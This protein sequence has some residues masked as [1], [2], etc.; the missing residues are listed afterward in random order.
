MRS[1]LWQ[2]LFLAFALLSALSLAGFAAWQ[3]FEFRRG[4]IG[5][6]EEVTALRV[7]PLAAKLGSAYAENGSWEFLR[8][9]RE[10]FA[11][12]VDSVS[13]APNRSRPPPRPREDRP[14]RDNLDSRDRSPDRAGPPPGGPR[15]GP[16]AG[17]PGLLPRLL[18]LDANAK[19]V[20]G[21]LRMDRSGSRWPIQANGNVVGQLLLEPLPA[22]AS[23]AEISFAQSQT[24]NAIVAVAV[25]LSVALLLAFALARWLL[26][27]VR[28][29][30]QGTRALSAGDFSQRVAA[31]RNDELGALGRDFNQLASTLEQHREARRQWGAD[32]SHELRTPLS[33]L[34]GEIQAMQDGVR[35]LAQGGLASLQA[36]CER[37]GNL[38]EDLYQLSL[39]DAGALEY[40]YQQTDLGE[41]VNDV[42]DQHRTALTEAGLVI[43]SEIATHLIAAV[44]ARRIGQLIDNLLVNS[45]RYTDAP[46]VVRVSLESQGERCLLIVEDSAPGVPESALRRLFDRLFRVD[47]SRHRGSG[48]AGLGLAIAQAIVH[49]HGGE[50]RATH[51]VFGG[52]RIEV[53]FAREPE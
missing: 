13:P 16:P 39:A 18:V 36:E 22:P 52:L 37:L 15:D 31:A 19:P 29:L 41:L 34:R 25:A 23:Q 2:K 30:T 17:P 27:P 28:A 44:D 12:L 51:S 6:L 42:L 24:R 5:Y 10:G 4:F 46:G 50:I 26:A 21:N 40:R 8:D 45:R 14:A 43:H 47:A 49:A 11:A 35:P 1:P 32:I 3:Q 38:I 48:G 20:I 53:D 9:D 33:I 7:Q